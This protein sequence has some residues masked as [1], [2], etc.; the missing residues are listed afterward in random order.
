MSSAPRRSPNDGVH[1]SRGEI[2]VEDVFPEPGRQLVRE[3][4]DRDQRMSPAT[5]PP[6]QQWLAQAIVRQG[7]KNV[8]GRRPTRWHSSAGIEK[9]STRIVRE[10]RQARPRRLGQGFRSARVA[11]ISAGDEGHPA[12]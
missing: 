11:T 3:V 8:A 5:A 9:A 12:T 10:H 6:R 4:R 1:E 2:E 7:L